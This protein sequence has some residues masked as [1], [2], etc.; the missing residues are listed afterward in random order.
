MQAWMVISYTLISIEIDVHRCGTIAGQVIV[1]DLCT[2]RG[3][4][5]VVAERVL[6]TLEYERI[7][8][9]FRTFTMEY[10]SAKE[11]THFK[12]AQDQP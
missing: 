6:R 3:E 10:I 11:E 8:S 5:I 1:A 12:D 7:V 9:E 2:A 4:S